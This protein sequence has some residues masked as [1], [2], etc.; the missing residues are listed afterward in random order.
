MGRIPTYAKFELRNGL[1][2][3]T[4]YVR[5]AVSLNTQ[6]VTSSLSYCRRRRRHHQHLAVKQPNTCSPVATSQ[7]YSWQHAL[8]KPPSPAPPFLVHAIIP[9]YH[10][11]S[12]LSHSIEMWNPYAYWLQMVRDSSV[13]ITSRYWLD[14]PGM[15]SR[16]WCLPHPSIPA[17]EGH[18]SSYT[19]GTGSFPGVK[20]SGRGVHHP[21]HLAAMLKKE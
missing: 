16:W 9:S 15:E 18:P 1:R 5:R 19:M 7:P 8:Y 11:H 3:W 17:L 13:G 21:P 10:R 14:G 2:S 12:F 6:A 20:R 4:P